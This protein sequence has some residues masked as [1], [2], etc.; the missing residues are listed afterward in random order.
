MVKKKSTPKKK[1]RKKSRKNKLL[2]SSLVKALGGLAILLVVMAI[3]GLLAHFLIP[4]EKPD[5]I[6][7]PFKKF[8]FDCITCK[9][10]GTSA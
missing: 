4:P 10:M 7:L 2:K 8:Y 5:K 3:A 9:C 1:T 6:D